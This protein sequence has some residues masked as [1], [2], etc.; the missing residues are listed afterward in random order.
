MGYRDDWFNDNKSNHGW[1]TCAKCGRKLRK[2]D[3]DIDHILPRNYGGGDGL[4]N[5]Q[6][7]CKHCNRS[8]Q[9][10]LRD[11]VPDYAR[12]NAERARRKFF[13]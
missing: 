9:D 11:T 8:K 2:D 3:A 7:L 6:G 13:D 10:S 4:D 1:Y 12:N 5:L